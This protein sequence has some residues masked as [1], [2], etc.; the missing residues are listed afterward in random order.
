M[1]QATLVN[2]DLNVGARVMEALSRTKIPITLC[3]WIYLPEL[4]EWHLVVASPWYDTKGPLKTSGAVIDAL[5]R[6]GIYKQVPIR[7]VRFMGPDDPLVK[8]LQQQVRQQRD[9]FVH[10]LKQARPKNGDQ[11]SLIFAPIAGP[12]GVLPARRFSTLDD[13]RLFLAQ[14]LHLRSGSIEDAIDEMKRT[15][16]SSVHPVELATRHARK[17]GLA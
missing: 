7:R 11:Y 2:R 8:A 13:L 17:L 16:V 12:G 3:K 9:G 6:A 10:I 4:E 1:D 5:E 14:D 15:G